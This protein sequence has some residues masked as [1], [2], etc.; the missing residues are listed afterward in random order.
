MFCF[1]LLNFRDTANISLNLFFLLCFVRFYCISNVWRGKTMTWFFLKCYEAC[2]G[3]ICL[4]QHAPELPFVSPTQ[5]TCL[6][7]F[8]WRICFWL[9]T[10]INSSSIS[11][12]ILCKCCI[13]FLWIDQIC[14]SCNWNKIVVQ[15]KYRVQPWTNLVEQTLWRVYVIR[16]IDEKICNIINKT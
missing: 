4:P 2:V 10:E 13:C 16:R 5:T 6:I 11:W 14:K 9:S 12:A 1:F 3:L 15:L 8:I 7:E